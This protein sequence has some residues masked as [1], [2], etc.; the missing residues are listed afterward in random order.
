MSCGFRDNA[1]PFFATFVAA[2]LKFFFLITQV[3]IVIL[4]STKFYWNMSCSFEDNASP[5]LQHS[6]PLLKKSF[7]CKPDDDNEGYLRPTQ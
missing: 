7:D 2:N 6:W 4:L 3:H 5:I 1:S